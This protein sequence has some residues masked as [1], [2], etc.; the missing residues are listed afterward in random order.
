MG[1]RQADVDRYFAAGSKWAAG[2]VCYL[3]VLLF[4]RLTMLLDYQGWG[5]ERD[6]REDRAMDI[7]TATEK[8]YQQTLA[9]SR[10]ITNIKP[11]KR[12]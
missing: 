6:A 4:L 3:G 1:R 9:G 2:L 10:P 12:V 8:V 11:A 7:V 5:M